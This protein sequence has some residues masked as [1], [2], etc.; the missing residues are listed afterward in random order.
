MN[1]LPFPQEVVTALDHLGD[2]APHVGPF[3]ADA[4]HDFGSTI[5]SKQLDFRLSGLGDVDMCWFMVERVDDE[6]KAVSTVDDN[7]ASI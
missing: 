7:H 5:A 6:P 3:D 1:A 4:E 2:Q